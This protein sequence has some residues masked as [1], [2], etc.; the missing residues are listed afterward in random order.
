MTLEQ[1]VE[2]L[3]ADRL[4]GR[5]KPGTL[6]AYRVRLAPVLPFLGHVRMHKIDRERIRRVY[7]LVADR[8]TA[9]QL[10]RVHYALHG[11]LHAAI[12][13]GL[14]TANPARYCLPVGRDENQST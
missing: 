9:A 8:L 11:T 10:A 4:S 2:D 14:L 13:E 3:Y 12:A 5:R 1:F 7:E 6:R